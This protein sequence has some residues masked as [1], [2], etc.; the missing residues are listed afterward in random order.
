MSLLSKFKGIFSKKNDGKRHIGRTIG[1]VLLAIGNIVGVSV[2]TI[3]WFGINN[4]ESN[5]DMVS[6]DLD[7]EINKVTAYKYVYPY[8]PNSTEF[9]NYDTVGIVKKYILEDHIST[10]DGDDYDDITVTTYNGTITL[11]ERE[12]GTFTTNAN[13]ASSKNVS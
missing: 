13:T 8:Y 11:G 12:T 5:I 9:I 10:F 6:G 7:V 1:F 4:R 2:A 3:A